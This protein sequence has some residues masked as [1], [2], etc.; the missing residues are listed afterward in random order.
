VQVF[1]SN[2]LERTNDSLGKFPL[3]FK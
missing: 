2:S 1:R 3:F